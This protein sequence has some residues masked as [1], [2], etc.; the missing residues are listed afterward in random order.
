MRR[1]FRKGNTLTDSSKP[2]RR[3]R[4][5]FVWI[6]LLMVSI[7]GNISAEPDPTRSAQ[8]EF[9]S[10]LREFQ[11]NPSESLAQSFR[12]KHGSVPV[13]PCS[14]EESGRYEKVI[15]LSYSCKEEKF[16]GFIYLGSQWIS[17]KNNPERI[18]LGEVLKIGKKTYLEVKP[19]HDLGVEE[20]SSWDPKKKP[21][22]E[23]HSD[24]PRPQ[25]DPKDNFGLQYFLSIAKHPA[26]RALNSGKEI[27]FDSSCP[28][29][30]L[31]KDSDFYWDKATYFS[32]QASCIPSSPYSYIRIKSDFLGK[33][34]LDDKDT[35][36]IQEGAKY[37]GKLKIHSIEPD[38][39]VWQ[40]A[41]IYNE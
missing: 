14:F 37:L 4:F 24:K 30:F 25:K 20:H 39:I 5:F 8:E 16:P 29:I 28:L 19:S 23:I 7:F 33:I 15:Y 12:R 3:N 31:K 1:E 26:K 13:T 40:D 2:F 22:K 21:N 17:W 6:L 11:K 38:K 36:Q 35:D 27:F 10:F 32:F 9:K 18:A 41:E 34:R